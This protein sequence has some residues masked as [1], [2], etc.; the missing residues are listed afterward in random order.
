MKLVE[1]LLSALNSIQVQGAF[2]LVGS[3]V[4]FGKVLPKTLTGELIFLSMLF[5]AISLLTSFGIIELLKDSKETVE[6]L[7]TKLTE[8]EERSNF[9]K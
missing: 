3:L 8:K 2:G 5:G 1:G 6:N 7:S 4:L 9:L